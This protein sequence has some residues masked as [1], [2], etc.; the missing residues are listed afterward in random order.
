VYIRWHRT[1][2]W[3]FSTPFCPLVEPQTGGY[4]DFPN[5]F[6]RWILGST[7]DELLEWRLGLE[8]SAERLRD[9]VDPSDARTPRLLTGPVRAPRRRERLPNVRHPEGRDQHGG[10]VEEVMLPTPRSSCLRSTC[11]RAC[12]ATSWRVLGSSALLAAFATMGPRSPGGCMGKEPTGCTSS[13][14]NTRSATS[15]PGRGAFERFSG[16]RRRTRRWRPGTGCGSTRG[17]RRLHF[18]SR[19]K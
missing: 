5:S 12:F 4:P 2:K 10:A 9:E 16:K 15:A 1:A 14:S 6:V 17:G 8:Y 19:A 13:I 7:W 18:T 11:R 3:G